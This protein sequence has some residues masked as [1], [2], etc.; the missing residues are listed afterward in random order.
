[1]INLDFISISFLLGL[2][3]FELICS[4]TAEQLRTGKYRSELR[5]KQ[6]AIQ[7]CNSAHKWVINLMNPR[8]EDS[9]ETRKLLS[10]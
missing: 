7:W 5:D 10:I 2:F 3:N 6:W 8:N 9:K 4:S 1:M